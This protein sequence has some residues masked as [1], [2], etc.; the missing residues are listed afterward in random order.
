MAFIVSCG[1][2]KNDN[3]NSSKSNS[4]KKAPVHLTIM[5][6][7]IDG[8]IS[9]FGEKLKSKG[10]RLLDYHTYKISM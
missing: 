8:T 5:G 9:E 1:N 4:S 2:G 10:F 6:I 7:P 3:S